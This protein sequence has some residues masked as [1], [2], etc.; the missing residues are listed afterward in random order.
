MLSLAYDV[1]LPYLLAKI[2][3][4]HVN[5]F[6]PPSL[7]PIGH[8]QSKTLYLSDFPIPQCLPKPDVNSPSVQ[9]QLLILLIKIL[10]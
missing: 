6:C 2:S 4:K 9:R 3:N 5:V 10:L 8:E 1:N 7:E